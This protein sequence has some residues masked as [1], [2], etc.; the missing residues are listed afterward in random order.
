MSVAPLRRRLRYASHRYDDDLLLKAPVLLWLTLVF[1]VRH[2]LLLGITFLPTTGEEIEVLR[3]LVRPELVVADLPAALVMAAGFRRR[4][5]CPNWVR[6]IW[7][8]AREILTLS[9]LIYVGILLLRL[10][11]ASM[12]LRDAIDEPLLI[13]LLLSLAVP[14]YLWRSRLVADVVRDCPGYHDT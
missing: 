12:P 9:I 1:L 11:D 8:R 2:L 3:N 13:S 7:R 4:R 5:P 10:T 6:R 14:V